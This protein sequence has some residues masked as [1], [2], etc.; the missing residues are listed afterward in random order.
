MSNGDCDSNLR[1]P[2]LEQ[3]CFNHLLT[4]N[5]DF[6]MIDAS[7]LINW[8]V[9]PTERATDRIHNYKVA[10]PSGFGIFLQELFYFL[11]CFQ[12][13]VNL[14]RNFSP[15][16][17]FPFFSK[18]WPLLFRRSF[19]LR[20]SLSKAPNTLCLQKHH[21]LLWHCPTSITYCSTNS[22]SLLR[23]IKSLLSFL[24]WSKGAQRQ[25]SGPIIFAKFFC[26]FISDLSERTSSYFP[27]SDKI[28]SK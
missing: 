10:W 22:N 3:I 17:T 1:L 27:A 13:F 2:S 16:R 25:P 14:F 19:T 4:Q 6:D 26:A 23:S 7:V 11:F 18:Q 21:P 9:G 28:S 24:R 5:L 20:L 15:K 8:D 12:T